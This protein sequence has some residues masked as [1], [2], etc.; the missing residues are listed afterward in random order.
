MQ[1]SSGQTVLQ[2][3]LWSEDGVIRNADLITNAGNTFARGWSKTPAAGQYA[4]LQVLNPSGSG[5]TAF[6]DMLVFSSAS[7]VQ[8]GLFEAST[9]F[10]VSPLTVDCLRIGQAD[11]NCVV[12]GSDLPSTQAAGWFVMRLLANQTSE[13]VLPYPLQL[14]AGTGI[15]ILAYTADVNIA[16]A[17]QL[18]EFS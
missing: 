13:L 2:S 16:A 1:F 15:G 3:Q 7:N 11:G 4:T 14:D 17:V 6:I 5:V 12:D 18:R 10:A 9:P 8:I